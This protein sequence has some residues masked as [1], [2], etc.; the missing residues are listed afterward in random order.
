M[1]PL[2]MGTLHQSLPRHSQHH[3][4]SLKQSPSAA[5]GGTC[6][7]TITTTTTS[8]HTHNNTITPGAN[9]SGLLSTTTA[10][11]VTD[12]DASYKSFSRDS[13]HGGSEQEDSPRTHWTNTHQ[14]HNQQQPHHLQARYTNSLSAD[15][16]NSY[17]AKLNRLNSAADGNSNRLNMDSGNNLHLANSAA[18]PY[19]EGGNKQVVTV[20]NSYTT[21]L[22]PNLAALVK[23][24]H[25]RGPSPWNHTYMEIEPDVDPVYEEIERERWGRLNG[26]SSEIMQVSD[27]SDEDIKRTTPSDISRQSSRSYNDSKP[28]LPYY[29]QQQQQQLRQ[30]KQIQQYQQEQF[31]LS[32]ERL[33]D[34]NTA[35]LNMD[36]EKLQRVISQQ[37]LHEQQIH[38]QQMHEQ[39][40]Q[41]MQL[42]QQQQHISRENLMTVAV[43]NGEQVV[44]RLTSPAHH[45]PPSSLNSPSSQ[46]F[47]Q[48]PQSVTN[49]MTS[50][51][52]GSSLATSPASNGC[53]AH[54]VISRPPQLLPAYEHHQQQGQQLY[55]ECREATA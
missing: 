24:S 4:R 20:P 33:R 19:I 50:S 39:L 32:E 25:G 22:N 43:L 29:S 31:A 52:N 10:N 3:I 46:Q 18:F 55:N 1:T 44:C 15:L 28:L 37:Q 38:D 5:L 16:K 51:S 35:Q 14:H 27:L 13:G 12:E 49:A 42:Q 23:T 40:H 11:N 47:Q 45:I 2:P 53:P 36:H 41:Q 9:S 21:A 54:L 34:F 26:N 7:H 48:L 8:T 6:T 30:Q 17:L